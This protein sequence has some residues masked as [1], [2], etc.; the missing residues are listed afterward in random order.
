MSRFNCTTPW[1][2]EKE[3]ICT[4]ETIGLMAQKLYNDYFKYQNASRLKNCLKSCF[5]M[6]I[7]PGNEYRALQ[8]HINGKRSGS[9]AFKLG[10]IITISSDH[11]SYI[12]LNFIAEVGGYVGLF[13]GYSVYQ[14]TDILEKILPRKLF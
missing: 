13:L 12:W 11:Y 3:N 1:G 7:R 4:N 14:V 6:K 8:P 2:P 9:I 10:K 5:L